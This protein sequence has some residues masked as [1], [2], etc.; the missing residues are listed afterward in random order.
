MKFSPYKIFTYLV[1]IIAYIVVIYKLVN[2][3]NYGD[4]W[5]HF[6]KNLS[7]HWVY[8]LICI[9]LMPVNI[10]MEAIKW[11][12][13]V[14]NIENISV[15]QAIAATLK[16]QVGAIATPNKLG[17]FPTRASSLQ[18]GNRTIGTIMGFVAAWTLSIVIILIGMLGAMLYIAEYHTDSVN[19]QYLMLTAAICIAATI[20]IFSIPHIA[21]RINSDRINSPKIKNSLHILQHLE[22]RQLI[23]LSAL[24]LVRYL[25]FCAQLM[26]MLMFFGI[27]I[28]IYQAVISIPTIYL[29]STITPTIVAS[30][31]ATRS[32]YAILILSPISQAAPTIALATS[33][34]WALNCGFPIII[35]SFLFHQTK[36]HC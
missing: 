36:K 10:L 3:D 8:L 20:L 26:F 1:V 11:R 18:P 14:V 22:A 17:D 33:L 24:S 35:G 2:Y 15:R 23:S 12:A 32:G 19:S 21:K 4:L 28:S 34:L 6:T 25:I 7:S 31:A 29:L 16:G 27:N 9:A 5:L 13:A 30:E